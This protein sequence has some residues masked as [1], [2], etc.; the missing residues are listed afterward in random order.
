[1]AEAVV[2]EARE[3]GMGRAI[4]DADV[5]AAVRAAMWEPVYPIL[6]PE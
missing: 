3:C 5:G 4:A 2:V 6:R 1:V